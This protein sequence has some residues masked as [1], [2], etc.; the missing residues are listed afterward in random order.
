MK[1]KYRIGDTVQMKSPSLYNEYEGKIT[2]VDKVFWELEIDGT[3]RDGGLRI[4]ESDIKNISLPYE[5]GL[6]LLHVNYGEYNKNPAINSIKT[7]KFN[8]FSYTVRTK[9]MSC[10]YPETALRII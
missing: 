7:Y 1:P 4:R 2:E 8:S 3:F 10:I 6:D 9:E 5:F